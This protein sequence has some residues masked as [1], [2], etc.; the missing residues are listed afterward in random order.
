MFWAT[1]LAY[2]WLSLGKKDQL[3]S[4]QARN[5]DEVHIYVRWRLDRDADQQATAMNMLRGFLDCNVKSCSIS[6]TTTT[7][8]IATETSCTADISKV[9]ADSSNALRE[10]HRW[11]PK[12]RFV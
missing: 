11:S 7:W 1:S 10:Q 3:K 5:S 2:G 12:R 4:T 6:L 9:D 8:T